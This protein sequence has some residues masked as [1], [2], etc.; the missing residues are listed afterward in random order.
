MYECLTGSHA[1]NG[2]T[3][4]DMVARILERE[5]DWNSL[6]PSTPR[7]LRDLMQ[8][9]M[10]KD[11]KERLRD[12]GEARVTLEEL[13][14]GIGAERADVSAAPAARRTPW[15]LMV[16]IVAVTALVSV[17][18]T[19]VLTRP[20][21]QPALALNI[22]LPAGERLNGGTENNVLAISPDGQAIVY[23]SQS[24]SKQRL[25]LRRLDD[26]AGRELAGTDGARNPYF[27]PDGEWV[28][29]CSGRSLMKVSVR[30]GS[31]IVL[32]EAAADRAGVWLEDGS[33]I[34]SP[35]F[36]SPL[37]R[38]PS[39]GGEP[40][41]LTVVDST[42]NERTHR[43]PDALPGGEWVVF[44][45][46]L[47][48]SPGGYDDAG[49]DVVSLKDGERRNIARGSCARY[50]PGGRL[51]F[52]REGSLYMVPID[53]HDPRGGATAVPVLDGVRGVASSG[54]AFFDIADNGTL[55]LVEGSE[56]RGGAQLA[57]V[58]LA[59]NVTPI[60]GEPR[61]YNNL[62]VSPDGTRALVQIGPGGG[63]DD[64]FLLD[65]QTGNL[66]QLTFDS[67]SGAPRWM[68]D[69]HRIVYGV[70]SASG[71]TRIVVRDL[72]GSD[73]PET[74]V[75]ISTAISISSVL[76]DGSAVVYNPFGL[77][78]SDVR[79]VS[80]DGNA[81][82]TTLV[83]GPFSQNTGMVTSDGKWIAYADDQSG[84]R[85]VCIRPL[86]GPGGRV[87][88][89]V[90]GGNKP[91][92]SPDGKTLYYIADNTV[93]SAAVVVRGGVMFVSETK[94]LFP[95]STQLNTDSSINGIDV[96]PSGEK[97]LVMTGSGDVADMRALS[98][99]LN[100]ASTLDA[101]ATGS[102]R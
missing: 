24:D 27:S 33:I 34:Y 43:W 67:V 83:S 48:N 13:S 19:R 38:I 42:R 71:G 2:D 77:V 96:H 29:F 58:D 18:A 4:S 16:G 88:V 32:T 6:P 8:R 23:T 25:M 73:Q 14:K 84:V 92:W 52:A 36:A 69:G 17:V 45:V 97:F 101:I 51:I 91:L 37:Y 75:E 3:V 54:I 49:I 64:V 62:S 74:L 50:A 10:R 68:P 22:A 63:A 102:G 80:T 85:E 30:G 46:G 79:A 53:P 20:P 94:P 59:G 5:P 98:I 93:M 76:P 99:R 65:L 66:N 44:T 28:A 56:P 81:T 55:L 35:S 90:S 57:W 31:P 86:D 70:G 78:D 15:A 1:F 47:L 100:W 9:C 87:Q 61:G 60:P 11:A 7:R 12:I 95:L 89:S 82:L 72:L 41:A 21:A 39:G 26:P 40:T